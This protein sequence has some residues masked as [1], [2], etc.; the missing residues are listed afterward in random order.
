MV[1]AFRRQFGRVGAFILGSELRIAALTA[2]LL[3]LGIITVS[4]HRYADPGFVDNVLAGVHGTVIDILV[5]GL[6]ILWL[7]RVRDLR[8]RARRYHEEIEDYREWQSDEAAHRIAGGI[9]RLNSLGVSKILLSRCYVRR[10]DLRGAHLAGSPMHRIDLGEA[11]LRGADLRGCDL[12]TAFLGHADLRG[13]LLDNANL[14]RARLVAAKADGA[15]FRDANLMRA[16]LRHASLRSANLRGCNLAEAGFVGTDLAG[17]DLRGVL[18]A[19][20]E[21]L[22]EA[23][24][25][26]YARLDLALED[27][28]KKLKPELLIGPRGGRNAP[29]WTA[30]QDQSVRQT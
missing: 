26:A 14:V 9:R 5:I 16:D 24:S 11:R 19:S 17:A 1:S 28:I 10:T 12:D 25:L 23:K 27:R 3:A 4:W 13:T 29:K 7:N 22:A 20:P 21:A 30:D 8:E 18:N 15:S 6:F 2:T